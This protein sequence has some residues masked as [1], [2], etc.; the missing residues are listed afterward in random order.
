MPRIIDAE[1]DI[2]IISDFWYKGLSL[3]PISDFNYKIVLDKSELTEE[4][5]GQ[6]ELIIEIKD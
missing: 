4:D 6:I 5:A 2:P 1:N 3:E